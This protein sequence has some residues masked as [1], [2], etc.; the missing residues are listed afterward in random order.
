MTLMLFFLFSISLYGASPVVD[1]LSPFTG[2]VAGGTAVTITG[3]GFTGA[4]AVNFGAASAASFVVNSDSTI[5]ATSAPH[6]P[7]VV[8]VSVTTA[9]GTSPTTNNS[10]FVYQG[11][12]QAVVTNSGVDSVTYIDTSTL[13]TNTVVLGKP[14]DIPFVGAITP[15]G[16]KTFVL[17]SSLNI[18]IAIDNVTKTQTGFT[19]LGDFPV[20][21]SITPDGT[22]AY[23]AN[24]LD[25]K[26]SVI[27]T[28]TLAVSSI[29][30][31]AGPLAVAITPDGTKAFVANSGDGSVSVINTSTNTV[32]ATILL[33][34]KTDPRAIAITPDGTTAYVVDGAGSNLF[35]IDTAALTASAPI[36]VGTGPVALA[37]SPDGKQVYTAN[38]DSGNTISVY[39]TQTH[40]ANTLVSTFFD[41]PASIVITP[42]GTKAYVLN[43]DAQSVALI[44]TSSQA[45]SQALTSTD[46][47]SAISITPDGKRVYV[48]DYVTIASPANGKILII[49]S[50]N[51]IPVGNLPDWIGITPDQAPLAK[52]HVSAQEGLSFTFDASSSVSPTGTIASYFWNFGDGQTLITSSAATTHH[53][54]IPGTYNVS[55]TVTNSAGTSTLQTFNYDSSAISD[56]KIGAFI[57]TS[58]MPM[59]NNGNPLTPATSQMITVVAAT[60]TTVTSSP[61]PS[62]YGESVTLTAHV[63]SA[64][65]TPTGTVTFRDGSETLCTAT[66][67][68]GSASCST[69]TIP[70]GTQTITATYSGDANFLSSSGTTTQ[71]VNQADT[72]TTASSSPN[73][74]T[75][76]ESVT[77]TA[78]VTS[79]GGTPTGSV[80]FSTGS[81]TLCTATLSGGSASCSTTTIPVG[82]QTITA[83][84]SGDANF[85]PSSGMTE[86]TVNQATTTTTV[87]SSPNPSTYGESVT[88]S[89]TVASEGGTPTGSVTFSSGGETLCTAALVA[90]SG[91][92]SVTTLPL[93]TD[94]ITGTYSGD[95][96]F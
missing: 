88:L 21:I 67:S 52:F 51:S 89:A 96:N 71:T 35:A 50:T 14:D 73:P 94:I 38:Y 33:G 16:A 83:T 87:S 29:T 60:T 82:T 65:G 61:N 5:T 85:L 57:G 39:N 26:V 56:L 55:L 10:Y 59:T 44:D 53:Y 49:D 36:P 58:S 20:A 2:P 37:I 41:G 62:T 45:V 72:T 76:G 69:T 81:E 77:L 40:M 19:P 90:G 23:V 63:T 91:S 84:Y 68:G 11:D 3:S 47:F 12:W 27:N 80:T 95:A 79:A 31:G 6:C 86:Q 74:S 30:V 42:D 66:L 78:D 28:A 1:N 25:T 75:Y 17:I 32:S 93:G 22:K 70:V 54:A 64:G 34:N 92:C 18:F 9:S 4:T 15:D 7:Q 13:N 24:F 48:A 46:F 8:S 43:F